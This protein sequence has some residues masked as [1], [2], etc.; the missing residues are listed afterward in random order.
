V[1][2][3]RPAWM[4]ALS[5]FALLLLAGTACRPFGQDELAA[6]RAS[7]WNAAAIAA[8]TPHFADRFGSFGRNQ[9]LQFKRGDTLE[10]VL[11]R[12]GV[13]AQERFALIDAVAETFDMSDFRAGADVVLRWDLAGRLLGLAYPLDY[14]E[15]LYA[16]RRGDSF[17]AETFR[18][19]LDWQPRLVTADLESSFYETLEAKGEDGNLAVR[20]ADLFGGEVDFFLDLQPGDRMEILVESAQ[21]PDREATRNRVLAAWL[22]TSGKRHAAYLNPTGEGER[23]YYHADGSSLERQFLKAPLSF[24]RIS[25]GF[26]RSRLHPVLG[27]HRPHLGVDYA[28]PIGTPVHATADGSVV[29]CGHDRGMGR[30]VVVKHPGRVET[31]YMHLSRFA[32]GIRV[33]T[34]VNKGQVIGAVGS[35]GLSTGPHLDYR[36]KVSGNFIDPRGYHSVAADPLP[37]SQRAVFGAAVAR[38]DSLCAALA[39]VAPAPLGQIASA[40]PTR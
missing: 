18:A 13:P 5:S 6:R 3:Q 25:S 9:T 12:A 38:Y 31:T 32:S 26:S 23:R 39:P 4:P 16:W 21:R 40:A 14:I 36:M 34:R 20:V 8:T 35:S 22:I 7:E 30:F 10:T 11:R 33:G 1:H 2:R 27:V 29:R 19:T 24:T 28:A 37:A 17:T 15:D